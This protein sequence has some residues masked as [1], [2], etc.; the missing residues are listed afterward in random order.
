MERFLE[1]KNTITEEL[2]KLIEY[3][4]ELK[5]KYDDNIGLAKKL[6]E[7][8]PDKIWPTKKRDINFRF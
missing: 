1:S 2:N 7:D 4:Q 5:S 3:C 6:N 8:L